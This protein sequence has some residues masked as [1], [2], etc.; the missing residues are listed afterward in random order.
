M[1]SIDLFNEIVILRDKIDRQ[2]ELDIWPKL[3]RLLPDDRD[4]DETIE[5]SFQA[6]ADFLLNVAIVSKNHSERD[7][8]ALASANAFYSPTQTSTNV[9]GTQHQQQQQPPMRQGI[10]RVFP[11]NNQ[12]ANENS[13]RINLAPYQK[14]CH[15]VLQYY[16]LSSTTSSD[17]KVSDLVLCMVYLSKMDHFL[18][19]YKLLESAFVGNEYE[20]VP[21]LEPDQMYHIVT[22][23]R[24]LLSLPTTSL[25]FDSVKLLRATLNKVMN[26]PL[27]KFPR[28]IIVPN[29]DLARDKRCTLEDLILERGQNIA[30]LEPQQYVDALDGNK[31]PYCDD[32]DFINELLKLTD[33]FSLPRMFFNA[34]NS[35]FYTTMENYAVT[36][37][38][39]DVHDYNKIYKAMDEFREMAE[40]CGLVNKHPEVSDS[41]N[42]YLGSAA[43]R[44]KY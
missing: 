17:F 16:T 12:R 21:Y 9:G 28:I 4:A 22:L 25:D 41:L 31:I 13:S 10:L 39:F 20:C 5:L 24:E 7:N 35:I 6:F 40:A 32:E 34:A 11:H 37:C 27:T 8:A 18:P 19:L 33:D 44:K 29:T 1:S 23:L 42:V 2:M 38:K 15:R 14:A 3:F 36:N 43:K 30:R 26:Y